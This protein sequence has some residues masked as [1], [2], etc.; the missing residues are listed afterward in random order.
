MLPKLGRS[1]RFY[2]K[3]NLHLE[4]NGLGAPFDLYEA[5]HSY[6]TETLKSVGL[7]EPLALICHLEITHIPANPIH[8]TSF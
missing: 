4:N 2:L 5:S 1:H 8:H 7:N 3:A 6:A